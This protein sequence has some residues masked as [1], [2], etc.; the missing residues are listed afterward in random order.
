MTPKEVQREINR[1]K[2]SFLTEIE[3]DH[4]GFEA[5][6][7]AIITMMPDLD[8]EWAKTLRD[9][10]EALGTIIRERQSQLGNEISDMGGKRRAMKGYGHLRS[11]K[12]GQRIEKS[13]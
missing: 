5:V 12:R 11:H 9:E 3:P 6:N 10:L 4:A 7:D 2:Q 1:L 13:V 8:F